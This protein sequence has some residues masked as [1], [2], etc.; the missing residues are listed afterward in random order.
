M[1][2]DGISLLGGSSLKGWVGFERKARL[3]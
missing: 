2:F 1:N 3:E